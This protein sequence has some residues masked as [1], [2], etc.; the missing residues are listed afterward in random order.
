M[1]G[2]ATEL[3]FDDGEFSAV[4][5]IFAP[6]DHTEAFRVLRPGGC[7]VFADNDPRRSSS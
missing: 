4:T 3:P 7:L 2:S 1:T 6:V 5:A